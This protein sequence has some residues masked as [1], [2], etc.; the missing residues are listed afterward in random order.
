MKQIRKLLLSFA[1]S[2]QFLFVI[3]ENTG[4]IRKIS[5]LASKHTQD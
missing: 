4:T 1:V 5:L 3:S 2:Y